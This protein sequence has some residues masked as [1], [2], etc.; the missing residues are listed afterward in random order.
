[1]ADN[2][3]DSASNPSESGDLRANLRDAGQAI[4][5]AGSSLG[6]MISKH[7]GK[8]TEDL[9]EKLKSATT[10][11]RERLDQADSEGEIRAAASNFVAEAEKQFKAFQQRDLEFSDDVKGSL[12]KAVEDARG[13]FNEKIGELRGGGAGT[14]GGAGSEGRSEVGGVVGAFRTAVDATLLSTI[15][16]GWHIGGL[17]SCRR[18]GADRRRAPHPGR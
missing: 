11:A 8:Y 15:G 6:A 13:L 10:S 18:R 16:Y 1:M 7:A 3:F 14:V 9:P 5:A 4:V 12:Q 17:E 2:S